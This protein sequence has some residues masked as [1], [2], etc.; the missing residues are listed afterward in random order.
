MLINNELFKESKHT[1]AIFLFV[2][3]FP[4]I[5]IY[6]LNCNWTYKNYV[7]IIISKIE[8]IIEIN[9]FTMY[10]INVKRNINVSFLFKLRIYISKISPQTIRYCCK[11]FRFNDSKILGGHQRLPSQKKRTSR[12]ALCNKCPIEI[13]EIFSCFSFP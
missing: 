4:C 13:S 8:L 12:Y 5:H 1:R 11:L 2:S 10:R 3:K 9:T 6:S 7:A